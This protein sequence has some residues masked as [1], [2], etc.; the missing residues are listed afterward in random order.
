M[1][2]CIVP[3]TPAIAMPVVA[4]GRG[5]KAGARVVAA[6]FKIAASEAMSD[7]ATAAASR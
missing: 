7:L 1:L 2:C 3:V 5:T 6:T 4:V